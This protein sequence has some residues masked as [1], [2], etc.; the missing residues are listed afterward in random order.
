MKIWKLIFG[1]LLSFICTLCLTAQP[2]KFGDVPIEQLR[3]EIYEKDPAASVIVLFDIGEAVIDENLEVK[4]KRH[5][6]MKILAD[7]GLVEGDISLRFRHV[8]PKQRISKLKAQSYQVDE[9]GNII[10]NKLGRREKFESKTTDIWSE[11]KFSIP[12]IKKGSVFEYEYEWKSESIYD[13]PDWYFQSNIP[14]LWSEYT[15]RVP[16]WFTYMI[17]KRSYHDFLIEEQKPYNDKARIAYEETYSGGRFH[18][19]RTVVRTEY[20]DY[21]GTEYHWAIKN[22]PAIKNEPYMKAMRDYYTQVQVQLSSIQFP[23]SLKESVLSTWPELVEALEDHADY[24]KRIDGNRFLKEKANEVAKDIGSEK[25]KMIALYDHIRSTINWN[26]RYK[27]FPDNKLQEVYENGNGTGTEINFTLIQMLKEIGLLAVPVIISTRNNG[28]LIDLYPISS[29]FNHTLVY[30]EADGKSYLLDATNKDRPYNVLPVSVLNVKGL[31]IDGEESRWVPIEDLGKNRFTQ[32]LKI[33]VDEKARISGQ[34]EASMS[35]RFSY[36]FRDK[37]GP[38]EDVNLEKEKS[39]LVEVLDNINID[40]V[41]VLDTDPAKAVKFK[42][43]F[44]SDNYLR[45]NQEVIYFNPNLFQSEFDNPFKL[46]KREYP[47][48]Y[49]YPFSRSTTVSIQ[50][51]ENWKIDEYPKSVLH[52]LDKNKGEFKRLIQVQG[53]SITI[54]YSLKINNTRIMPEEYDNL[55]AMYDL[56][57]KSSLENFVL[58]KKS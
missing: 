50:I 5:I 36:L 38:K 58:T 10:K 29:Q 42:A 26:N 3:M 15:M 55:K 16:E 13:L 30:V 51:P 37:I 46:K 28:E 6:R 32:S 25:E 31:I 57:E 22:L 18:A 40:S 56:M 44:S 23:G 12:N 39:S 8:E 7:E 45:A 49:E 17:Y 48:D 34:L 47:V 35:G 43:Y 27:L 21:T 14:V 53:N 19:D 4:M 9:K 24:G 33:V 1:A 11:L 20:V 2:M 41:D 54:L 52:R